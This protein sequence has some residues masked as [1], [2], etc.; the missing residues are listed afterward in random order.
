MP[1]E[2][3]HLASAQR[4]RRRRAVLGPTDVQDGHFEVDL[5]PPTQVHDFR[6]SK[7][8]PVGQKHHQGIAVAVAIGLGRLNELIDLV[9]GQVFAG[10]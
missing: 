3:A 1:A 6:R 5:L 4:M 2:L 9:S 8:M 7:A 10:A